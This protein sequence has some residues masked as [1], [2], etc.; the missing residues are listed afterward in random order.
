MGVLGVLD[1][2]GAG[3]K[4]EFGNCAH[5]A[6]ENLGVLLDDITS[7][8]KER[9]ARG[10]HQTAGHVEG[11][12]IVDDLDRHYRALTEVAREVAKGTNDGDIIPA[13]LAG[14]QYRTAREL[15]DISQRASPEQILRVHQAAANGRLNPSFQRWNDTT[16]LAALRESSSPREADRFLAELCGLA[17]I[18]EGISMA[19][20][21]EVRRGL[22]LGAPALLHPLLLNC[23]AQAVRYGDPVEIGLALA[24]IE[25]LPN[26]LE[27]QRN[28]KA[29]EA[30]KHWAPIYA[31][32][33]E[34]R[35]SNGDI[36]N[37]RRADRP[38]MV[39]D[40]QSIADLIRALR[41]VAHD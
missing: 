37:V 7:G 29:I 18:K 21:S 9:I 22:M 12:V 38:S 33:L 10:L 5:G 25:R 36:S 20:P 41:N 34:N 6:P 30:Y 17:M 2:L 14:T 24:S 40:A 32:A 27:N 4:K 1:E 28:P 11:R 3:F 26:S 16:T 31:G 13:L 19:Q 35:N 23:Y 39:W 15:A 8:N